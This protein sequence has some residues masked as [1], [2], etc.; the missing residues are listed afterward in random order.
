MGIIFLCQNNCRIITWAIKLLKIVVFS[1]EFSSFILCT[2]PL[3][4][5]NT[6]S[7]AKHR[8]TTSLWMKHKF[9]SKCMSLMHTVCCSSSTL[10]VYHNVPL[11]SYSLKTLLVES[12][13]FTSS[14]SLMKWMDGECVDGYSHA[15]FL[16][17]LVNEARD[18]LLINGFG[19]W[20][21]PFPHELQPQV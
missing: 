6:K 8:I 20:I 9:L 7:N 14:S 17:R 3:I 2:D 15:V 12:S 13:L 11:H 4:F 1:C 10:F 18:T 19:C 21:S 5:K 16:L